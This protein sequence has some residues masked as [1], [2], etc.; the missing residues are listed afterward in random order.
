MA[1]YGILVDLNRCTGCM[2]CVVACK[3]ENLT[4]PRVWW[5]R[6][7][8]LENASLDRIIYFRNACMH[9]DDPPC[10]EACSTGAIYKRPDGIVLIDEQKCVGSGDCVKACPYGVIDMNPDQEY[11]PGAQL[12]F[13]QTPDAHR[14][15]PSGKSS[16]CTLCVHRI[17]QGKEPLCVEACPS[18]AMIFYDLDNPGEAMQ[19]KLGK[20][21]KLLAS[22]EAHPK[23]SYIVPEN[24]L[25]QIDQRIRDNP[26]MVR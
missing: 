21:E 12:P 14:I 7:L 8:E 11:F 19:E 18:K 4:R 13:E 1:R 10:V 25:N 16:K 26:K 24:L 3:H 6:I 15:H 22:E 20:S 2:T 5:N 17:D 9:C 23:V